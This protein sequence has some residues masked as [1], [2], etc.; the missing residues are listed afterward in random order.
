MTDPEPRSSSRPEGP[1]EAAKPGFTGA[2]TDDAPWTVDPATMTW[3]AGIDDLRR[4]TSRRVPQLI[5]PRRLPPGRRALAV[6]SRIVPAVAGWYFVDRRRAPGTPPS[7]EGLS[8]RLRIAFQELGPTYIKLGQI[9]SA[10][11]G[12]FPPEVVREFRLLRDRVPAEPFPAVA[13]IVE[14]D[15]GRPIGDVFS[16]FATHP[17]AAASI[18]QVHAATLCT[19]EEVVVKVQRPGVATLVRQDIETMSWIAPHLVGRIPIAALANPPALVELFASTIVE[20][21]DFRLE[22]QNMLDIA[23]VLAGAGASMGNVR[24]LIVPRPHPELVTRRILVMERIDGL[25]WDDTDAI[26]AAGIDTEAVLKAGVIALIEGAMF[27]GVFHGDLHGGNLVVRSNG[28]VALLDFGITGRLDEPHRLAYLRLMMAATVNDI[29]GQV[30]AVRDA[31][32]LPA[33]VDV[34]AVIADLGLDRPPLDPTTMTSE[35]MTSELRAIGKALLSYGA[36]MP[37]ELMLII[38]NL[39]FLDASI[40]A[41][42]PEIDILAEVADIATYFTQHHGARIARD[43]GRDPREAALDLQG[44][45]ASLGIVDERES[46]SYRELLERRAVIRRRFAEGARRRHRLFGRH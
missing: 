28:Q 3:R 35:E 1:G 18:A 16:F 29:H 25:A 46:L 13:R 31:G 34:D 6:V 45:R 44:V 7:R 40:A 8:R 4:R 32:A 22:A 24:P 17:I 5:A 27:H 2:F 19:G 38:K 26:R 41:L 36:R 23:E 43:V 9:I 10:G 11:E 37:K 15:L 14:E 39:L 12:I 42:A 30:E 33:D 21:L 20:E